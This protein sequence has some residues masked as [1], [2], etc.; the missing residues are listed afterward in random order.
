MI[1]YYGN[2]EMWNRAVF[3]ILFSE[4]CVL[5]TRLHDR[6]ISW[7][8]FVKI[9]SSK[10]SE[11]IV[12]DVWYIGPNMGVCD[13]CIGEISFGIRPT[14][15]VANFF[16]IISYDGWTKSTKWD[17]VTEPW[18]SKVKRSAQRN[19]QCQRIEMARKVFKLGCRETMFADFACST[20]TS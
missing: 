19:L 2:C 11:Q 1:R 7:V 9:N 20:T 5:T 10:L 18:K 4:N 6:V 15:V 14:Q 16:S 17:A 8:F 12:Y 3:T 13:T